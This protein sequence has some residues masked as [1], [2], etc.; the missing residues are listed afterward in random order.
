MTKYYLI[1]ALDA[2]IA[3]L[4]ITN[5]AKSK[6]YTGS[7]PYHHIP[8]TTRGIFIYII[9]EFIL[10]IVFIKSTLPL[11]EAI[12]ANT[13]EKYGAPKTKKMNK[14]PKC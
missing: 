3:I 4:I 11:N 14:N 8:K 2:E 5:N 7:S 1:F 6:K 10:L 12:S 9:K 13:G